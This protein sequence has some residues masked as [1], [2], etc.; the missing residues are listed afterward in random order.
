MDN[1][2]IYPIVNYYCGCTFPSFVMTFEENCQNPEQLVQNDPAMSQGQQV[3][4]LPQIEKLHLLLNNNHPTV[5]I[6]LLN[7]L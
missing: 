7:E 3:D 6:D 2:N 1:V 5:A 4:L